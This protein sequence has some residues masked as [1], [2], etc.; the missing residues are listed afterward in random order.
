MQIL[1]LTEY[2]YLILR[3]GHYIREQRLYLASIC[4]EL[5]L[6]LLYYWICFC[7]L[8]PS[9]LQIQ[10]NYRVLN[11]QLV[12]SFLILT[13]S[14]KKA[15]RCQRIRL[16]SLTSSTSDNQIRLGGYTPL[17]PQIILIDLLIQKIIPT[18]LG[19][20]QIGLLIQ[21]LTL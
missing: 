3:L 20:G 16:I 21:Q 18:R 2:I 15:L 5:I 7:S 8:I 9:L 11:N 6:L 19:R 4:P 17:I 1:Y 13:I 14:Y 12:G 10:L